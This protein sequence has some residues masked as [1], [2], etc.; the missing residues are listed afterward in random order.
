MQETGKKLIQVKFDRCLRV[1]KFD[2]SLERR[3]GKI[4]W[5]LTDL[6]SICDV[7]QIWVPFLTVDRFGFISTFD[8]SWKPI[9]L[10]LTDLKHIFDVC[11]IE[12]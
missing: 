8:R 9:F 3:L 2:R 5:Y 12:I 1:L 7:W 11:Q 4:F 10:T 6:N